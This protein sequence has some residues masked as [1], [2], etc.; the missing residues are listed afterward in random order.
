M[1][2]F[3]TIE[4]TL[5][6]KVCTLWLS[7]E[8]NRNAIN[9][10]MAGEIL[11]CLDA[12]AHDDGV[13]VLVIRGKG[14]VFCAGGDLNWMLSREADRAVERPA[15]LLSQL[16]YSLYHFPKPVI[17]YV[18]GFAMGGAMG[19]V[20]CSD[21]VVASENA[22][23]AFSEVKLGLVPATISPFVVKRIGEFRSRQ[24]M[25]LGDRI[26][27][28]EAREAGLADRLVPAGDPGDGA[29]GNLQAEKLLKE[30]AESLAANAPKAMQ[31]CKELV[32]KVAS[33]DITE[34]LLAYTS[35]LLAGISK[36]PE[37]REGI[38]AFLEKR[39]PQWPQ[40]NEKNKK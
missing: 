28:G 15:D 24:L 32:T 3:S 30:L 26:S 23:F 7:R 2:V 17:S 33:A 8:E 6:E 11:A 34:D 18:H 35:D 16:F 27:A 22:F 29:G 4:T 36:G 10:Q 21:F 31:V 9:G 5:E 39:R 38:S 25:L 19:L 1:I 14:K 12:L 40:E 20:A 37:A 13:R